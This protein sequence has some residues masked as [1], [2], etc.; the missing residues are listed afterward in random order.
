MIHE[1]F[2]LRHEVILLMVQK[3]VN[4]P[5]EVGSLS[6]CLQVFFTSQVVQDFFHQQYH[7]SEAL[8]FSENS[9]FHFFEIGGFV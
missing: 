6:R 7:I 4:S 2:L 9:I 1:V 8:F 5:V 3:S